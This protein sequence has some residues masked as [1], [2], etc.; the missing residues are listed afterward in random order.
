G[1]LPRRPPEVS[2][3]TKPPRPNAVR[4][5]KIDKEEKKLQT[6]HQTEHQTEQSLEPVARLE[7]VAS[8]E[9]EGYLGSSLWG[10]E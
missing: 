4:P 3:I 7:P 2:L 5:N 9:V 6:E 8:L 10:M 1:Y